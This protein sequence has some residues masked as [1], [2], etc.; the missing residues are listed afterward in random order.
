MSDT[1]PKVIRD[2]DEWSPADLR[3]TSTLLGLGL[4]DAEIAAC[5]GRSLASVARGV[6]THARYFFP[7]LRN[8]TAADVTRLRV[9][10]MRRFEG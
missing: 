3:L 7:G 2:D 6:A 1:V 8:P 9:R 10:L 4:C 5:A